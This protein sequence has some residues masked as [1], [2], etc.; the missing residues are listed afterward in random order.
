MKTGPLIWNSELKDCILYPHAYFLAILTLTRFIPEKFEPYTPL[1][2][3][4]LPR[5]QKKN[6]IPIADT[7]LPEILTPYHFHFTPIPLISKKVDPNINY[8]YNF[9]FKIPIT[10]I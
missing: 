7:T 9:C 4:H 1:V 8:P 6:M 2:L 10:H 5:C 3:P